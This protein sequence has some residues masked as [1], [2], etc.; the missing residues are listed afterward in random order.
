MIKHMGET[1]CAAAGAVGG[2]IAAAF[3]GWNCDLTV[4]VAFMAIDYLTG[5]L[6][7]AL[8]KS[9]K[10]EG[11]GLSSAV[12]WLGLARKAA[13]LLLVL[14]AHGLD[15]MLGAEYVRTAAVIAFIVNEALSILENAGLLGVP[16]PEVIR[17]ALEVLRGR[18]NPEEI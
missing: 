3:G 10:T 18:E 4:L 11:G 2:A 1:V 8:G 13:T 17:K 7:A 12:G 6:A 15:V 5:L 16:L 9:P 14:V